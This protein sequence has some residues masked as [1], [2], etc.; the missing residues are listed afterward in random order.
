MGFHVT[1]RFAPIAKKIMQVSIVVCA[2]NI[3]VTWGASALFSPEQMARRELMGMAQDYYE[4]FFYGNFV[5]NMSQ[6][7]IEKQF[8]RYVSAGF[9]RVKLYQLLQ[10]DDSKNAARAKYFNYKNYTC[11]TTRTSV[12]FYPEAP[13]SK[14]DYRTELTLDCS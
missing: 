13:F 4:N 5:G 8:Q 2:L 3:I 9:P 7:E 11:D 10:Y 1:R 12:I 6:E 14:T